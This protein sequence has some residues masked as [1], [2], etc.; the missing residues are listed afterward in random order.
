VVAIKHGLLGSIRAEKISLKFLNIKRLLA[1]WLDE[2]IAKS[3]L[4]SHDQEVSHPALPSNPLLTNKCNYLFNITTVGDDNAGR[5]TLLKRYDTGL[6]YPSVITTIGIDFIKKTIQFGENTVRL[7]IFDPAGQIRFRSVT[8][9]YYRGANVFILAFDLKNSHSLKNVDL[10]INEIKTLGPGG[11]PIIFIMTKCDL[12]D[13]ME[14]AEDIRKAAQ[15]VALDIGAVKYLECSAKSG[16]NVDLV[17]ETAV[18]IAWLEK[19]KKE[20][21]YHAVEV[22]TSWIDEVITKSRLPLPEH[23]QDKPVQPRLI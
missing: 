7:Q 13:D 19:L 4:H 9:A 8:Q 5:S 1:A 14:G 11:I 23:D 20:Y 3:R 2:V 17:F 10:W 21:P 6:F 12:L 15:Q 16:E 22:L 18:K